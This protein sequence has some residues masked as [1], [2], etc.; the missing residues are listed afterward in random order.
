[1]PSVWE[2]VSLC[3]GVSQMTNSLPMMVYDEMRTK[4]SIPKNPSIRVPED[5]LQVKKI[6]SMAAKEDEYFT[7]L[8]LNAASEVI[9]CHIV[10]KGV[11]NF[12][13]VHPRE[14]YR[15]AIKDNAAAIICVHNHPSG[16]LEPSSADIKITNQLKQAGDILE[17]K[18][19]DHVIITRSGIASMRELGYASF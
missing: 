1:M 5:L 10:T 3:N 16:N 18:L 12:S 17:I 8:T 2:A 7:V 14:I 13:V 19:L 6:A 15:V 4:Y 11:L 9:R